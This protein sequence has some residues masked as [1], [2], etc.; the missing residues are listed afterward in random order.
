MKIL[1]MLNGTVDNFELEFNNVVED[2]Q[3]LI[4]VLKKSIKEKSERDICE[5]SEKS[6]HILI[7][8]GMINTIDN[9]LIN[10]KIKLRIREPSKNLINLEF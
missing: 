10:Q 6:S 7:N 1:D 9:R 4:S 5:K 8:L 2:K 3:S